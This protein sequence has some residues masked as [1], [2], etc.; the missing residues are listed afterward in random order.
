MSSIYIFVVFFDIL[1]F[2]VV[3]DKEM[4]VDFFFYVIF[5]INGIVI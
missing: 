4:Y 2:L 5:N 3:D 1:L